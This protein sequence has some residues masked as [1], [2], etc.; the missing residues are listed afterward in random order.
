MKEDYPSIYALILET[1]EVASD[2]KCLSD[3]ALGVAI[4]LMA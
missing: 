3:L 2:R 1:L 4:Y